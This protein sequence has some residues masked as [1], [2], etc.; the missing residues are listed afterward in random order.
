MS[1]NCPWCGSE[2]KTFWMRSA[3]KHERTEYSCGSWTKP[4][5]KAVHQTQ[6][7]H[8]RVLEADNARLQAIV[9][10]LPKFKD[11]AGTLLNIRK[12]GKDDFNKTEYGGQITIKIGSLF[13]SFL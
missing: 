5:A 2:V 9:D 13:Q 4:S 10:K 6:F 11:G 3:T 1:E 12:K 8:I 7:C